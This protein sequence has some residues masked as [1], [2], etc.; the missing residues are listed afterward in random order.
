MT[1]EDVIASQ[2]KKSVCLPSCYR[3]AYCRTCGAVNTSVNSVAHCCLSVRTCQKGL[4]SK[5]E[6]ENYLDVCSSTRHNA[7]SIMCL[8]VYV[9]CDQAGLNWNSKRF[10]N[11]QTQLECPWFHTAVIVVFNGPAPN[12]CLHLKKCNLKSSIFRFLVLL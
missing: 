8:H 7:H 4:D 2:E 5:V 10:V 1:L 11:C 3:E 6:K 9:S 12:G